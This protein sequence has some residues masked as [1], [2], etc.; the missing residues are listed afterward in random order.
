MAAHD[1]RERQLFTDLTEK[2]R[3][4]G[5]FRSL[6]RQVRRWQRQMTRRRGKRWQAQYGRSVRRTNERLEELRDELLL[7]ARDLK[8][9]I[10]EEQSISKSEIQKY[11]KQYKKEVAELKQAQQQLAEADRAF[12]EAQARAG[13]ATGDTQQS[14]AVLTELRRKR[15]YAARQARREAKELKRAEEEIASERSDEEVL[16]Y[17]LRR[18]IA[19]IESLAR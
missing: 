13:A 17:E 7:R 19:E 12:A 11:E 18:I 9:R 8:Q 6:S 1:P 10:G 15:W 2:N 5:E 14:A 16:S 4:A 3:L